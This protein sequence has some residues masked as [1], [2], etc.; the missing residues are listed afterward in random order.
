MQKLNFDADWRFHLGDPQGAMW[1]AP[2]ESTWRLLD[3]PHDWSIELDR[4]PEAPS[5][6]SGGFFRTGRGWY[7]KAFEAPE[8]WAG[9]QVML[10]FEGIYMNAEIR[11]NGNV[12][13][14]H[15]YGYT[16]FHLDLTSH[17]RLGERNVLQVVVDND[18]QM[19]SRW[20]SGSGIYRHVWL[21]VAEPLH[22]APWGVYVTTPEIAADRATINVETTL[23]NHSTDAAYA[24]V[25]S[26]VATPGG[27]I[28]ASA[29]SAAV[30]AAGLFEMVSQQIVVEDPALWSPESPTLYELRTEL[31]VEDEIIDTAL[32]PFGI[33]SLHFDASKGFLLNGEPTLL[34]GGCVHHDNGVMGAA[35]YDRSE[36]RKVELLKANGYNAIRCAH[37]PPAPAFLDACDRLGMLVIDEAF[38][39]WREGKMPYDYH[40][41][42]ADWWQRDLDSM[43]LRDRN[44]PSVIMWSIGN[45]IGE[46]NG[47]SD[48]VAWAHRLA[49]RVRE[50][51]PTRPITSGVNGLGMGADPHW[52]DTDAIFGALDVGGYNYQ[53]RRYRPDHELHPERVIYGS[54]ST[55]G[56]AFDH[57]MSVLE[58]PHVIG[59]FVWTSLDYLGESGIGR[60]HFDET[61]KGFLGDYPWHQANCGDLDLCGF[62]RPQ[63]YYRDILW[64]R[65]N[66][67]YIAVHDPVPE[68]KEPKPTYW[69]WPEVWHNWT[70]PG[71]EGKTFK[72][73]VYAACD[74][75][76]LRLNGE[77]IDR[78]PAGCGSRFIASFEVPYTPGKLTAVGITDGREVAS[79]ALETVGAPVGLRL[80]P[81][82]ATIATHPGDLS[83][84]TVEVI[85]DQGRVHPT[86]DPTVYFTV[87]GAGT[88][89]A[90]GNGNPVSEE[91]YRG[92]VRRAYRG[93]CLAVVQT[94]GAPGTIT[95][96][97][98]ADGLATTEVTVQVVA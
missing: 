33:R 47:S 91:R 51:D 65:G 92:N 98:Q 17:L 11:L 2:D 25:R 62:K 85:D 8:A 72:V 57:W 42:F 15:P 23:S 87:V 32:T 6:A 80:T 64:E 77:P 12:L 13:T 46:R 19:N 39:C 96:R 41:A 35:S 67:L 70:W 66:P 90:V 37:N 86:A 52:P 53:E 27:A 78:Q 29:E 75:V 43:V 74:E 88:L 22:V 68:D 18:T 83:F 84:V 56:E 60:V 97:A 31:I 50:L 58:L 76:E 1:R 94:N 10:E 63:S 69:G 82:R 89:A 44:H 16:S 3:L 5:S 9:K 14:R 21:R 61:L 54:E 48:G 71:H 93:S 95:L 55:A 79:Q 40:I 28:I 20:Y 7:R 73:D 38:D 34:Y 36:E 59:D 24:T 81:D 45:E 49:D 30:V 4:S 26:H